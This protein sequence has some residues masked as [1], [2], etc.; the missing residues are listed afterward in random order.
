MSIKLI[1]Y[2]KGFEIGSEYLI[3]EIDG[4]K[5]MFEAVK[6]EVETEKKDEGTRKQTGC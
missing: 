1:R 5:R 3:V 6:G 4:E 2:I